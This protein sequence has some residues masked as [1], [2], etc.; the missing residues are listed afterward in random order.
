MPNLSCRAPRLFV[1]RFSRDLCEVFKIASK[2]GQ[3]LL[4]RCGVAS[5]IRL[6]GPSYSSISS[7]NAR[8][9]VSQR[10]AVCVCVC[11][12]VCMCA[13]VTVCFCARFVCVCVCVHIT[14]LSVE[15]QGLEAL[16]AGAAHGQS[17]VKA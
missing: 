14:E 10:C 5:A 2:C 15:R 3:V 12:C 6:H 8:R 4:V 1:G 17:G 11:V 7:N 13:R 9:G 16:E